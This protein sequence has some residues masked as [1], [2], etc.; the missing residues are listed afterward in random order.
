MGSLTINASQL[1]ELQARCNWGQMPIN[2]NCMKGSFSFIR[3]ITATLLLSLVVTLSACSSGPRLVDHSFG[4][5][6]LADSPDVLLLDYR[7]GTSTQ[8][9]ARPPEWSLK[10]GIIRQQAGITG[11]MILGDT[12]YVKWRIKST[13]EV[14]EDTVDLKSR[15]PHDI[16]GY[17]IYF[18]VI[19]RQLHVYLVSST[20]RPPDFPITGPKKYQYYKVYSIYPDSM[21]NK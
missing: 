10:E 11:E 7:Y 12:L 15:L 13:G 9:G 2:K 6:V 19:G 20:L 4:F 21:L 5:D 1:A 8:P 18:A 16:T 17:R 14:F 3:C